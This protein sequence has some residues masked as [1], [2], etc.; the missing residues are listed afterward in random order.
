DVSLNN[1]FNTLTPVQ[2]MNFQYEYGQGNGGV[3]TPSAERSWGPRMEGQMVDHWSLDPADADT[4]QY[5]FTPQ[6]DNKS[7]VYQRGYDMSSNL[8]A[9]IGGE[10]TQTVFSYTYT[11][12]V[13]TIPENELRRHNVSVR[14][15]SE[16]TDQFRL[17]AK[18]DYSNQEIDGQVPEG[19]SNF[20]RNRQIYMIPPNI[21]TEHLSN[22][23]YEDANGL[24]RQNWYNP[25]TT[26]GSNPYW[27]LY[28]NIRENTRER[29][30]AMTSLTYDFSESVSFMVRGSYDGENNRGD[31]KFYHDTFTRADFGRYSVNQGNA[32]QYNGD[33]LLS[34][35]R[36][37]AEDWD[38]NANFGGSLIRHENS[39][40][41]SNTGDGLLIPNYFALSNTSRVSSSHNP[42]S[43][44]ETQS[45]YG[46]GQIGWRDLV[47]LDITGRNDWSSTLPAASRSYFYPS[48]GMSVILS[49]LI[50]AFPDVFSFASLRTSWAR[51]GSSAPPYM[52]FRQ[53]NFQAGGNNGYMSLSGVLP[54]ENLLPEE[55]ESIEVG[56]DLR[57]LEGRI[58]LDISAY[59]TNTRNQ[60]F[61]IALP[62]VSGATSFFTNGGDVENKG[63]E[64]VLSTRPVQ[65]RELNVNLDV[66]F[67]LNRNMVNSISDER[68]RVAIGGDPYFLDLFVEQGRPFGELYSRG[69]DR[70]DQGRVIVSS[71]GLPRIT[72]SSSVNIGNFNPDWQGGISSTISYRNISASFLIDHR[73]GGAL[74]T[75]TNAI[76]ADFGQLEQTLQGR[77]GGLIFGDNFFE[78]ETAVL[79]DGSPNNIE[80]NAESFWQTVGGESSP[81]G[82]V[83]TEDATNTRLREVTL[84]YNLPQSLVG[85][86]GLRNVKVSLVGRNLFFIYK[87]SENMDPDMTV[88]T[89]AG[90]QGFQ[91]FAPPATR[92][93]G[94]NL[95]ID[96]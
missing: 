96:F 22:F 48:V 6:P 74:A 17:D 73:Q 37:I 94:A 20:N 28:R 68:P 75:M 46:F 36:N 33:F 58:G 38:V 43:R 42:G 76:L 24:N 61:T 60:L 88:G 87:A 85:Q 67:A 14:V 8:L 54:N 19:R 80:T 29:V 93:L 77:E 4:P 86:L 83:F 7:D 11:D 66:N 25:G 39:S 5:A 50:P 18:V 56:M 69:F 26:T 15:N 82:E 30:I 92:T 32:Q 13:G 9:R 55:T 10:R 31:E 45:L 71:N 47:Y 53:A 27:M 78:H 40:I 1:T 63:L 3:Y 59:K 79:E 2:Y 91:N 44:Y 41:S 52:G 65:T 35:T 57:M 16:L 34:Y 81:A 51:V 95:K 23:E 70:D 89:G 12:A 62:I 90:S 64:F 21:R 72:S 49:D 84:G